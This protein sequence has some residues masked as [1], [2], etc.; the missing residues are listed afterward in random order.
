MMRD[1]VL[2]LRY[3]YSAHLLQTLRRLLNGQC[4]KIFCF[5]FFHESSSPQ[6]LKLKLGVFKYLQR[7]LQVKVH[8]QYQRHGVNDIGDKFSTGIA[9]VIDTGG[10]FSTAVSTTLAVNLPRVSTTPVVHL[11]L[12]ISPQFVKTFEHPNRILRG[13]GKL[14]H[15]KT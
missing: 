5:R 3:N 6:P 13:W 14:I 9:G 10:K 15:E 2:A 7:Y 4:H 8:H 11:D 12:R 1:Q